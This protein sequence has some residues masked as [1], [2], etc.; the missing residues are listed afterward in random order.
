[1]P[2]PERLP[3]ECW[4]LIQS[5]SDGAFDIM[6]KHRICGLIGGGSTEGGAVGAAHDRVPGPPTRVV[7]SSSNSAS[8]PHS[9]Y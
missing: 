1:V 3:V 5:G 2:G 6:A 8:V 7:A 4:Q 9:K